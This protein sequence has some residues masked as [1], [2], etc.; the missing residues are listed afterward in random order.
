MYTIA[1]VRN[2]VFVVYSHLQY[3]SLI[4][5]GSVLLVEETGMA[6]ENHGPAASH[7]QA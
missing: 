7:W 1:N 6:R 3:I 5:W 2:T 4:S